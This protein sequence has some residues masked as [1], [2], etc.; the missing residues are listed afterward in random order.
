M[1]KQ[2]FQDD[3]IQEL[4]LIKGWVHELKNIQQKMVIENSRRIQLL[5]EIRQEQRLQFEKVNRFMEEQSRDADSA[6]WWKEGRD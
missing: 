4:C 5:N 6:D 3:V 2:E 1:T